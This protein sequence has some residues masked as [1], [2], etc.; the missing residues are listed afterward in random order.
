VSSQQLIFAIISLLCF[1]PAII[2]HEVA[3][4]F[5]ANLLGDPT[6]KSQGRITLNPL[7]HVDPFGTVLLPIL[8][9]VSGL[10]VFGYAK[11]VPYNP[12][13]FKNI[14]V[15]EVLTGIA[16]PASNLLM[17]LIAA[18]IAN[19]LAYSPL[20]LIANRDLMYWLFTALHLFV[21]INL[22]LMFFNL[23][24]LP[25]LDGSSLIMP[26]LPKKALPTW[27]KVQRY[28]LPILMLVVIVLPMVIG[29]NPL[30]IYLNLTAGNLANLLMP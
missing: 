11:P 4:G 24:P 14:R 6:A 26:F 18:I 8:L 27:Y 28:A 30:S 16:G 13:Y 15:G 25:P 17:A 22:Y 19:V 29:F 23:I 2:V 3:H 10:P 7:K 21:L 1:A 5:V 9:A 12:R 20:P